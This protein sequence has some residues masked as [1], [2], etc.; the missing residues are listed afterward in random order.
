MR[1]DPRI[2]QFQNRISTSLESASDNARTGCFTFTKSYIEPCLASIASAFSNCFPCKRD[3]GFHSRHHHRHHPHREYPFGFY[4]YDDSEE[5]EDARASGGFL[6]WGTDEL[7]RLLAGSGAHASSM[8]AGYG[9]M[10]YGAAGSVTG[11]RYQPRRKSAAPPYDGPDPTVIPG[12]SMFGFLQSLGV[13]GR[14][15]KYKPSAAN[16]QEHP[17]RGG[18]FTGRKRSGTGSSGGSAG[19]SLRSRF[20]LWPSEDEDDAVPIGDDAFPR[21]SD[22]EGGGGSGRTSVKKALSIMSGQMSPRGSGYRIDAAAREIPRGPMEDDL[23]RKEE[24]EA[25][26]LEEGEV[27]RKRLAARRLAVKR[28]LSVD[29][30]DSPRSPAET[31]SVSSVPIQ[32]SSSP[33]TFIS[34]PARSII[35]ATQPKRN[36]VASMSPKFTAETRNLDA[37]PPLSLPGKEK[38]VEV[39]EN[40]IVPPPV[41][42]VITEPTSSSPTL[43]AKEE[44]SEVERTEATTNE[45]E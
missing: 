22:G 1:T 40:T 4:D 45:V 41:K 28:G 26:L 16:L 39:A 8:A 23:L 15:L 10:V 35:E 33:Q 5:E 36:F 19:E 6:A 32:F 37:V 7:D 31:K 14:V 9:G 29:D 12:T 30:V 24:E 43:A 18:S 17:Q 20:D 21:S 44:S 38:E 2:R 13:G 27:E 3:D 11:G 34:S 42:E 25:R